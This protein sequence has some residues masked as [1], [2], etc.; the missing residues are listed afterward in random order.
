M[1]PSVTPDGGFSVGEVVEVVNKPPG[2]YYEATVISRLA[3]GSYVVEY[4]TLLN[5]VENYRFLRKI[6]EPNDLRPLPPQ[7][8]HVSTTGF[9]LNQWV[10]VHDQEGWWATMI[11]GCKESGD[12]YLVYCYWNPVDRDVEFHS[13]QLRV[14]QEWIGGDNWIF[15]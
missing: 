3:N 4:N 8:I 1:P 6:V 9:S 13:D 10:D 7:S 5:D 12:G 11:T 14:H 2:S 15:L